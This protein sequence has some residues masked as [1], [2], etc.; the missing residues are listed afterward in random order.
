MPKGHMIGKP[1]KYTIERLEELRRNADLVGDTD[2]RDKI[3]ARIVEMGGSVAGGVI[4][5]DESKVG[6]LQRLRQNALDANDT[7]SAEKIA[8][9]IEAE[10]TE[11]EI[12]APEPEPP[13]NGGMNVHAPQTEDDPKTITAC[14]MERVSIPERKPLSDVVAGMSPSDPRTVPEVM[15]DEIMATVRDIT[16]PTAPE[17]PPEPQDGRGETRSSSEYR[18]V[19]AVDTQVASEPPAEPQD[20]PE[21]DEEPPEGATVTQPVNDGT[22]SIN[23]AAK[24]KKEG[25][26][27]SEIPARFGGRVDV[28]DLRKYMKMLTTVQA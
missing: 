28:I 20:V 23:A 21:S 2:S 25:Y 27:L 24:I 10:E 3:T 17:A 4:P 8:V 7:D 13:V 6:R 19:D 11:E 18:K 26:K 5:E 1:K 12:D 15:A 9:L 14:P 22:A 16:N